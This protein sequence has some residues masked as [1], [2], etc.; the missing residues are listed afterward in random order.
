M[1]EM[2][3]FDFSDS[4]IRSNKSGGFLKKEDFCE[5]PGLRLIRVVYTLAKLKVTD[6]SPNFVAVPVIHSF[7]VILEK[8]ILSTY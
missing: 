5:G 6:C 2:L 8:I 1:A 7:L 4:L 3:L